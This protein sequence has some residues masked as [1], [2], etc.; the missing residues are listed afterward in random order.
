[1]GCGIALRL[2]QAGARVTVLERS[3]PG[4]EASSAAAGI[5]AAQEESDGP[6]A[7]HDLGMRSREL[8]PALADELRA[9][10][11][12]DIGYRRCG[13]LRACLGQ[14]DEAAAQTRYGWQ[15]GTRWL[16]GA[17]LRAIEPNLGEA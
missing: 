4:A 8:F 12:I 11:G 7:F 3:V 6:G 10:T 5:L 13:V 17:D 14:A 9:T 16:R 2:A 1:M 15:P